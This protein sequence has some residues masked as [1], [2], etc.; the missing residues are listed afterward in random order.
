VP[1]DLEEIGAG[2]FRCKACGFIFEDTSKDRREHARHHKLA[3]SRTHKKEK[4]VE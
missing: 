1:S 3:R 2:I 4:Q